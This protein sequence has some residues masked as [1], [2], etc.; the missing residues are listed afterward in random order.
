MIKIK[1]KTELR[2][3]LRKNRKEK[4]LRIHSDGDWNFIK[5]KL[6]NF[7]TGK[8]V[9]KNSVAIPD[10][11]ITQL[12]KKWET[13]LNKKAGIEKK[14]TQKYNES[15]RLS[16]K[17]EELKKNME[18]D[19][20][21]QIIK[22]TQD[23]MIHEEENKNLEQVNEKLKI[24]LCQLKGVLEEKDGQIKLLKEVLEE[25]KREKDEWIKTL[26]ES[27]LSKDEQIKFLGEH[28]DKNIKKLKETN[29]EKDDELKR[30]E[31]NY[32]KKEEYFENIRI[33]NSRCREFIESYRKVLCD[34]LSEYPDIK[35][36][37]ILPF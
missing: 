35:E 36:I 26:E 17:P 14:T 22:K 24:E 18:R 25:T 9:L 10:K 11:Q 4:Y 13:E 28:L 20:Q 16:G 30:C 27:N 21:M 5:K 34:V 7:K 29:L 19:L 23:L 32:R 31:E 8:V 3:A 6:V 37:G 12:F 33:E 1:D 15:L 2:K